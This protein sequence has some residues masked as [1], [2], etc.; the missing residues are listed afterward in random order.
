MMETAEEEGKRLHSHF[1]KTFRYGGRVSGEGGEVNCPPPA[2]QPTQ[3]FKDDINVALL[4]L[5]L[6]H[7][8][9]STN[10]QKFAIMCEYKENK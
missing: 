2:V 9:K 1:K 6:L 5:Y 7:G 8:N 4:L 10:V 3:M